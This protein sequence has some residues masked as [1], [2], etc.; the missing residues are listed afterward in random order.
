VAPSVILEYTQ[1][2]TPSVSTPSGWVK[3]SP[4][5]ALDISEIAGIVED[6]RK[7]AERAKTAGFDGVELHEANGYLPDEFLQD[8]SDKRTDATSL[9]RGSKATCSSPRVRNRLR[10]R[11]CARFS[12]GKS[13]PRAAAAPFG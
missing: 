4:H 8:G 2:S 9:N 7:A 12:K 6:Y 11:N 1:D 10:R 5:R 3:P 13:S